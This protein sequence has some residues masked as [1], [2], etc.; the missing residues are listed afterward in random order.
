M[1]YQ[2]MMCPSLAS[3]EYF[4]SL[5]PAHFRLRK[6][7]WFARLDVPTIHGFF[8]GFDTSHFQQQLG[9]EYFSWDDKLVPKMGLALWRGHWNLLTGGGG[10]VDIRPSYSDFHVC[11]YNGTS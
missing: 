3:Q 1:L 5:R 4:S 2:S 6:I 7:A 11:A 10:G 9:Q 8:L